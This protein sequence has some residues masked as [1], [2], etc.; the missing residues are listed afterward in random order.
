M[1]IFRFFTFSK[2]HKFC[3][4]KKLCIWTLCCWFRRTIDFIFRSHVKFY[5]LLKKNLVIFSRGF[6]IDNISYT[7]KVVSSFLVLKFIY[8]VFL[9]YFTDLGLP[10][11]LTLSSLLFN[12]YFIIFNFF[13]SLFHI[14]AHFFSIRVYFTNA[15]SV[16]LAS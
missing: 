14:L 1:L 5:C 6:C 9:P 7:N 4:F 12:D 2:C 16:G 13:V 11:H 15:L 10:L 8:F 3:L